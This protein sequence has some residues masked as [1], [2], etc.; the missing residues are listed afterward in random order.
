MLIFILIHT[1]IGER[2]LAISV[3]KISMPMKQIKKVK[4]KNCSNHLNITTN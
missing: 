4:E 1:I 2:H 3:I